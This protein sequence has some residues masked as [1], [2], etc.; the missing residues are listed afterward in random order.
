MITYDDVAAAARRLDGVAHRTPVLTS[1]GLDQQIGAAVFL[2]AENFQRV[3]AFKFRGAFN[4]ISQLTADE[5][6]RGVVT[7]S[8]GNHAQ[9]VALAARLNDTSATIL[10]P[11]DAPEIKVRGV[12]GFGGKVVPFDRYADD[13]EA[14]MQGIAEREGRV[15]VHPFD[16]DFVMAGQGTAVKELIEE[17][18]PL[19]HLF[20]CVGGGG[21]ISGSAVAA[22]ALSPE[23]QVIGVEPEAGNDV[24][25]SMAA[26]VRIAIPVPQTIADGQQ[27]TSPGIRTFPV[28]QQYVRE[29]VTVT[30]DEIVAAMRYGFER[31]KIVLEPSGACAFA[32]VLAGKLDLAGARVGVTLSGGNVDVRRFATLMGE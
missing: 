6:K 25:Q 27:T 32:A 8:S 7:G 13:R 29:I 3:G 31:L 30:D 28:I 21:L 15:L 23:V 17:S 16:D 5:K 18:G 10:M 4:R 26:G 19:T 2:K 11:T 12:K 22:H 14:L 1:R 20:V 24:Q 9:A